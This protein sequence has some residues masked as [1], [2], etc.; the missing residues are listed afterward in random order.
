M[1]RVNMNKRKTKPTVIPRNIKHISIDSSLCVFVLGHIAYTAQMRSIA[2]DVGR[3]VVCLWSHGC[4]LH[5]RLN[6]SRC[7]M[8]MTYVPETDTRFL[9]QKT[10][11]RTWHQFLV[12]VA[13]FLVPATKMTDYVDEIAAVYAM[14]LIVYYIIMNNLNNIK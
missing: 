6:R 1:L 2:T 10:G 14:T 4:V 8:P 9:Y 3:S 12:L 11:T 7:L 5:K 13:R